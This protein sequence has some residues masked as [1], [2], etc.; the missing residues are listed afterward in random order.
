MTIKALVINIKA[1]TPIWLLIK[2]IIILAR[3]FDNQINPV[4]K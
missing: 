1:E 4:F 2:K 3:D